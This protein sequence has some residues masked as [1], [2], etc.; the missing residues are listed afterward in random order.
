MM[1]RGLTLIETLAA[2][3][4]LAIIVAA[5]LPMFTVPT[6]YSDTNARIA[7][8][9]LAVLM[10]RVLADPSE[11]GFELEQLLATEW[12]TL[13]LID[14]TGSQL[15]VEADLRRAVDSEAGHVWIAFRAGETRV[16]RWVALPD[17]DQEPAP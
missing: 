4:L 11:S 15:T 17:L 12:T 8:D 6:A 13:A 16:Y 9:E 3:A 14:A 10:D 5:C 7:I 1:R 2:A